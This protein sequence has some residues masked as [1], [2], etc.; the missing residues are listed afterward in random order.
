MEQKNLGNKHT[1]VSS[2]VLIKN[3]SL[4]EWSCSER[5]AIL[6]NG[7]YAAITTIIK[8]TYGAVRMRQLLIMKLKLKLFS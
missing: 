3:F 5:D 7:T 6:K 1:C 2:P 8:R 4:V